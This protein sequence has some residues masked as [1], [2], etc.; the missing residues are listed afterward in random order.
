MDLFVRRMG[1]ARRGLDIAVAEQHSEFRLGLAE[2]QGAGREG[3][4]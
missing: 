1:V 4:A 2:G 3:L